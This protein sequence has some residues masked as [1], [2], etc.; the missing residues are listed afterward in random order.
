MKTR[1]IFIV[2]SILLLAGNLLRQK[3]TKGRT[4]EFNVA[5]LLDGV[6][7]LHIYD[8]VSENPEMIPIVVEH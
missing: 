7:Y 3:K 4:V 5:N 1:C 2:F 6:Y 8:G